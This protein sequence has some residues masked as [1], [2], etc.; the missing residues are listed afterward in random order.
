[1]KFLWRETIFS[2]ESM[3][4]SSEARIKIEVLGRRAQNV[5]RVL[6]LATGYRSKVR[7]RRTGFPHHHR[8]SPHVYI[9]FKGDW[10]VFVIIW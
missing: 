9:K 3:A 5:D 8:A 4:G 10:T 1:M 6:E 2:P 7:W